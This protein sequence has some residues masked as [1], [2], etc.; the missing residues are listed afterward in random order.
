MGRDGVSSYFGSERSLK[1]SFCL[2]IP[3]AL[4]YFGFLFFFFNELITV[5]LALGLHC[6]ARASSSC[7]ERQL[8]FV[9]LRGLLIV[10]SSLVSE[11]WLQEHGLQ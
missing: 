4:R 2:L 11:Y 10:M 9:A 3:Y 7:S 1:T 8:L 5:L 6:C